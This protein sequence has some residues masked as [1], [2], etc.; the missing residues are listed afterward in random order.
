MPAFRR[1][2][3]LPKLTTAIFGLGAHDLQP[4]HLVAAFK[5]MEG[6]NAPF[7]YLGSQFFTKTQFPRITALQ[8][9]LKAAYPET[10]FMALETEQNPRLLPPS[11][12][13]IRF[14][15]V[16]GYGTI[17]TGKLLTDILA[18][19]LEMRSKAAP[20]YG[21]EKSG[22]PTNYYITL[23]PEPVLITNAE[24]EDVEIVISPDHKVFSHT[25]PLKG[26]V[27][28]GSF[29]LQTRLEPL[30]AWREMPQWARKTIREKNIRFFVVDGFAVAKRHAP[31]PDLETRM[32]GIA[33][34]GALC[35]HVDRVK[36]GAS[37]DA[38]LTKIRDQI[39]YK[40]GAKGGA[41]VDGNMAVIREGLEA[42]K[43]V[44]Y[45]KPEF[46]AEESAVKAASSRGVA[47][48][49]AA[50]GANRAASCNGLFD[51][52]YYDETL[53]SAFK[54]G[55]I[56]EAPV[57]PGA[58]LFMPAASSA[59]KD[60]GLFRRDAPLFN[61]QDCTGCMECTLV[62]PDAAIP[63]AVH[64]IDELLHTAIG[65]LELDG[66]QRE[67]IH[68]LVPQLS[69]RVRDV[70]AKSKKDL[71]PFHEIVAG[72]A[73]ELVPDASPLREKIGSLIHQ[74]AVYPVAKTK[75]F[76]NAFEKAGQGGGGLFA[77]NI[78][79]WKCT[80]CL[81]CVEVCGP[82][83][84]VEQQQD[85][86]MLEAMQ[87]RFEFFSRTPNTPERFLSDALQQD[88]E[89][90][91]LMLDRKN[92]YA[93]IGGHGAC[94][95]CGEVTAIRLVLGLNRGI[96]DSRR[97]GHIAET[98]D[99]IAKLNAKLSSLQNGSGPER[100]RAHRADGRGAG[101]EALPPGK[102]P[103]RR[104]PNARD[105][106][107]RHG[108]QQRVCLDLPLQPVQGPVGQQPVPGLPGAGQGHFRRLDRAVYRRCPGAAHRQA[109]SGGRLRSQDPRC[110]SEVLGLGR[111]HARRAVAAANHL[112][113]RRRRRHLRHRLRRAVPSLDHQHAG[114]GRRP[115]HRRLFE[116]RRAGIDGEPHWPG[117]RPFALRQNPP[118]QAGTA[119]GA[120]D[121][122][123]RSSQRLRGAAQHR[124]ARPLPE[125]RDGVPAKH[126]LA[127]RD[128]RL[129]AVP[130][131]AWHR[132]QRLSRSGA[133][134]RG[135]PHEPCVR[136][137]SAPGQELQRT[138]LD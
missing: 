49:A 114:Q 100:G 34:I 9:R 7:V 134:G 125:E 25:N 124:R 60:K 96:Q 101:K 83:A 85:D 55:S 3:V 52:D 135:K 67:Q 111:F 129:H 42:T 79:P 40:F 70:Y 71:K 94:R 12:F 29:I 128:R 69:E 105:H 41:V 117:L 73:S 108:L 17:A 84:L 102:R 35:G 43:A 110:R 119:Q 80:G 15:S 121:D 76:F 54:D 127:R 11:A 92:Y 132:R 136:A 97:A 14:H 63:N 78:D 131:G 23:S 137:R 89:T 56:A 44:D 27:E 103:D 51:R 26:L 74:L 107:Q 75:P 72:A 64:S 109:R 45:S 87:A 5:N 123:R 104:R 32:M 126:Q 133:T 13:R 77:V 116:H 81:E 50:S 22:A 93:T 59:W 21:S 57:L 130:A 46:A 106:R 86:A 53:A 8:D 122:R 16:G 39:S 113:H 47:I 120:W 98:Q 18:G 20:K 28:G 66:S 6:R 33:F 19:V 90:K 62:C 1:I 36:S 82:G 88:G 138:V 31:T 91:R 10:E 30:E 95:G 65:M 68:G 112:Q 61:A 24:L 58:G 2:S 38:L 115:Q 48:S 4:R 118:W 37:Q 99:L